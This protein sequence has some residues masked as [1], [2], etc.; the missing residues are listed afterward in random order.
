MVTSQVLP[1]VVQLIGNGVGNND[2]PLV[3]YNIVIEST[4]DT[5][6]GGRSSSNGRSSGEERSS[7]CCS[8]D[9]TTQLPNSY[10]L[11]PLFPTKYV[12]RIDEA[13]GR[14]ETTGNE[15]SQYIGTSTCQAG[16]QA[17]YAT[18]KAF[19]DLRLTKIQDNFLVLH[20]FSMIST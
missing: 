6:N 2:N 5:A 3:A 19:H 11:P 18:Y 15:N 4:N 1:V 16:E 14:M 7:S 20:S 10:L 13:T 12:E 9:T 8:N 17:E